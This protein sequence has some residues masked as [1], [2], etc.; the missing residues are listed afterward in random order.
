M[1]SLLVENND[2]VKVDLNTAYK[3]GNILASS[4]HTFGTYMFAALNDYQLGSSVKSNMITVEFYK[5]VAERNTLVLAKT[6]EAYKQYMNGNIKGAALMYLELA[7]EGH[8]FSDINTG[9]LFYNHKIFSNQTY[10]DFFSY[11]YFNLKY[12]LMNLHYNIYLGDIYYTG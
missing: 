10:N 3:Y 11:K 4:A 1:L 12:D 8:Q 5:A 9:I 2:V 7:N 6:K